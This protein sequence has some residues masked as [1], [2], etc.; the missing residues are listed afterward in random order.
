MGDEKLVQLLD[1]AVSLPQIS[2]TDNEHV[3]LASMLE[4]DIVIVNHARNEKMVHGIKSRLK[5][6]GTYS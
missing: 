4:C 5:H 3:S 2:E 1:S 6:I